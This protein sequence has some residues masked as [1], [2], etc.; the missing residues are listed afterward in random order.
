MLDWSIRNRETE[1]KQGVNVTEIKAKLVGA[2]VAYSP[3]LTPR[4]EVF[5]VGGCHGNG[6]EGGCHST[7]GPN[8][9]ACEL[10]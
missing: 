8:Q 2:Y 6:C 4:Y 7:H 1:T 5:R 9:V 10:G 3:A